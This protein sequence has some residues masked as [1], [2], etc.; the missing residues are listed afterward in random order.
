MKY[1]VIEYL[2]LDHK[3]NV[4]VVGDIHGCYDELMQKLKEIEFDF[5]Q[6]LLL[7]VGDL[8][9]RGKKNE[10]CVLLIGQPWFKSVRGNH[11]QTAI[12]GYYDIDVMNSH[13]K[14]G[15]GGAWFY[16]LPDA[17]KRF[18]ISEFDKL[19]LALEVQYKGKTYGVAHA[20]IPYDDWNVFKENLI[21]NT[22]MPETGKTTRDA[23]MRNRNNF[24]KDYVWINNID[25]VYL[26]HSVSKG[27]KLVG[28]CSYIDTGAVFG[29][30]LTIIKLGD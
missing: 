12:D 10:E 7:S 28:N 16:V 1:D 19:P 30:Y 23:T 15:N 25:K 17:I 22:L 29:R 9:D 13:I 5:E 21:Q 8:T 14:K 2:N 11:E 4:Y 20:E 18:I 24:R 27:I 6:D 26:G 3:R